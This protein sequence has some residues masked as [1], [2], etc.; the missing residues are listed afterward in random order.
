M[1]LFQGILAFVM[2]L[3]AVL[4]SASNSSMIQEGNV[5]RIVDN[6]DLSGKNLEFPQGS[7]IIFENGKIQN[8]SITGKGSLLKGKVSLDCEL[9]GSFSNTLFYSSWFTGSN[10]SNISKTIVSILNLEQNVNIFFDQDIL[11]DGSR[12][13]VKRVSFESNGHLIHN[14]SCF[15]VKGSVKIKGVGFIAESKKEIFLDL[16]E[17]QEKYPT[18]EVDSIRFDAAYQIDRFIYFPT[19]KSCIKSR[20]TILNSSFCHFNR[21]VI[22]VLPNC[23]GAISA[24]RF[25]DIGDGSNNHISA[26]W[27]GMETGEHSF[28]ACDFRI[29]N[30]DFERIRV[31]YSPIAEKRE[32]HAILIYGHRNII[33]DNRVQNIYS[34]ESTDGDPGFDSEGIYLKGGN[35]KVLS[36][37]LDN[38]VG[39][40]ADGAITI[41][42][43]YAKN[44]IEG[45]T[46]LHRFGYGIQCY[47]DQSFISHNEIISSEKALISISSVVNNHTRISFN[48]IIGENLDYLSFKAAFY[49]SGSDNIVVSSNIVK[50]IPTM[51][52]TYPNKK[53]LI[54]SDNQFSIEAVRYG[55]MTYYS[56]PI[57][58]HEDECQVYFKKNTFYFSSVRASQVIESWAKNWANII[59]SDNTIVLGSSSQNRRDDSFSFIS[60]LF[61]NC[62]YHGKNN[63]VKTDPESSYQ[64]L[65]N[66]KSGNLKIFKVIVE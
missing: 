43:N 18:I 25:V 29:I 15:R 46:I 20:L 51:L 22:H 56:A 34:L 63:V 55:Q 30:N 38:A 65:S 62:V 11:M 41:K 40:G 53:K 9:L 45:N 59:F 37:H 54:V 49:I 44:I 7:V 50:S 58:I 24:C 64:D 66:E 33:R 26:I 32:A 12:H 42:S 2:L 19:N 1:N 8:G 36:N 10:P 17:C 60:Y 13:D 5:F 28:G 52:V 4:F 47:T 35:N 3:P 61:R 6:V 21:F 23:S 31:S 57:S 27:L 14:P 16:S 48:T 39:S